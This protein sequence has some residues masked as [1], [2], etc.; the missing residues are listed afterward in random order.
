MTLQHIAE[1]L[2]K[3]ELFLRILD[4]LDSN[5]NISL[6]GIPS[7]SFPLIIAAVYLHT[8][9]TILVICKNSVA[10]NEFTGNLSAFV[11]E[12]EISA[13]PSPDTIPYEF[14]SPTERIERERVT[15][16]YRLLS[17][18]RSI[19]CATADSISRIIPAK[20]HLAG[21]SILLK[22][23][24]EFTF[25][26]VAPLLVRYGY[27]R[28]YRVEAYG[29]FAI[30]GGIIDIYLPTRDL[31]VRIEFFG[32]TVESIR[33]FDPDTQSSTGSIDSISIVPRKELI[34]SDDESA[35]LRREILKAHRS[36]LDTSDKILEKIN[37]PEVFYE[38]P[39]IED[40]FPLVIDSGTISDCFSSD[41]IRITLDP[42]EC[43]AHLRASIDTYHEL[44]SRRSGKYLAL[45][46][47]EL[48]S[49]DPFNAHLKS[50]VLLSTFVADD[51]SY[52]FPFHSVPSFGGKISDARD[53]IREMLADGW[54]IIVLTAFDGQ[55]RRLADLFSD[56]S[57]PNDFFNFQPKSH[58]QILLLSYSAGLQIDPTQTL[59]LTDHDIFGKSYRRRRAFKKNKS[60]PIHS[61][62][63]LNPGDPVVHINHGIGIFKSIERM[64][65]SGIERDY[66]VIEYANNDK[67][68]VSL[69]QLTMVQ[70]YIG[71][72]GKALRIDALGKNSAWNRIKE[73]V[74]KSVEE[75][76]SDLIQI[77]ARRKAL[78]GYQYP[79][80]TS[81]QEEFEAKFEYDETPDQISAIEDVKDDMET[82]MPMDRLVCGDVGFG[83]TEVAI[84]A[85]FKAVM[86]GRQVAILAP[87]TILVTQHFNTFK[88]RFDG[89]PF[90]IEMI[91]RFR[92]A[93]EIKKVKTLM[94]EGGVDVVIGTH[95][96]LAKDIAFKNLGLLIID[97]EQRFG[98]KHKEGIKK[99]RS[100]VD[101][102]TLSATPIPRTLHMSMSGIR[103]LSIIAT[104]PENRQSVETYVL[105]D[106]IDIARM[107]IKREIEREGQVFFVHNRVQS[108]D[109]RA[110]EIRELVPYARIAVAHGQMDDHE[111]EEIM[112][113]F[114][115]GRFDILLA[116]S[117][118]ESGLDMPN[119]N[120]I[121]IDRADTFGLS[122]LYQLKGRVG[123][124]DRKSYAYL[125]HPAHT[126]LTEVAQKRLNVIAEY[127]DLGSGFKIA[128]KDLEIRGAGNILGHEQSGSIMDVGFDLYC[129][130][131]E[132]AVRKLKGE[133]PLRMYRTPVHINANM[134]IPES[135]LAD[136]SQKMEFYK[137]FESCENDDEIDTL[138]LELID[139]FGAYPKEIEL[140]LLSER[141]R[142]I[143]SNLIIDE[144]IEDSYGFKIRISEQ[145][146]IDFSKLAS[147]ISKDPRFSLDPLDK[148]ILRF[149]L[150]ETETEKKCLAL[151]KW[152]Q[153]FV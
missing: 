12:S 32:D 60:R 68:Y 58:F 34:L 13:Y 131:L 101:V 40:F 43:A 139:R 145:S 107:A 125:F 126:V 86:A 74:Q 25:D 15:T 71:M 19:V 6:E 109:D 10:L 88:R 48:I 23:G 22:S 117:I 7:H 14:V 52:R 4:N 106:N 55:A 90:T 36:G 77:Y 42:S 83:K 142:A 130:M 127:T 59:I 137:R 136:E 150:E 30:K 141:I 108:I 143:A 69:D 76:A 65:A 115:E 100:Q 82:S 133:K 92:S 149:K 112:L 46:P 116:T 122:Q 54:R 147:S 72:D 84:R 102:L 94:A 134:F 144:I 29:Q 80:D 27:S 96:L 103:D 63:E 35:D 132:D 114:L 9:T 39:G 53:K 138:E 113:S 79:A 5:R 8:N 64:S 2:N 11:D 28:E 97:E 85:A 81:W 47:D 89:Y 152:L 66:M 49:I 78:K 123:R 41:Y 16:I 33:E 91:S 1:S 44:Y 70:K 38:L 110:A 129:Q 105:E 51:N 18:Y 104:P 24:S 128:M 124:S 151:K 87:T 95:A 20:K 3:N 153:Q 17:E 146:A 121:I 148:E 93:S 26:N 75:I 67:L 61:F 99:L 56:F 98:V 37:N 119:V 118:I 31:P 57:P 21:K 111:L 140:L 62:I 120:T 45:K 50:S 73:R 135:Y